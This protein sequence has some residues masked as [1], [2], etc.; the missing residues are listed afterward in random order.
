[1]YTTNNFKLQFT[2][3]HISDFEAELKINCKLNFE[4]SYA[5]IFNYFGR[6]K[7]INFDNVSFIS[8]LN[9]KNKSIVDLK[10]FP[11]N[12]NYSNNKINFMSYFNSMMFI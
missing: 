5:A 11:T 10:W 6:L 1:M 2:K 9:F 4:F 8:K 12:R 7:I 3:F